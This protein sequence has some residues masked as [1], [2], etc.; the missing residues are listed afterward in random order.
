MAL[1][2][3]DAGFMHVAR[4]R[5]RI[6]PPE[7]ADAAQHDT[8]LIAI[9]R[10]VLGRME[11]FCNRKFERVASGD[12]WVVP[13]DRIDLVVPRFPIEGTP[14]V[15]YQAE[16][17]D[18]WDSVDIDQLYPEAGLIELYANGFSARDKLRVTY[19]GGFWHDPAEDGDTAQPSGSTKAPDGLVEAWVMQVGHEVREEQVIGGEGAVALASDADEIKTRRGP[20]N[21]TDFLDPVKFALRFYRRYWGG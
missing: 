15:E 21:I 6:L 2:D 18:S 11:G 3:T 10:R 7:L 20:A 1:A 14:T 17:S 8:Q 4:L 12:T 13:A 19:G 5:A 9:G 16:N